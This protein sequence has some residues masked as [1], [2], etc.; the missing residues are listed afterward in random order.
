MSYTELQT[1]D[2]TPESAAMFWRSISEL[3]LTEVSVEVASET[4][5]LEATSLRWRATG[6]GPI[7]VRLCIFNL[8]QS[9]EQLASS[10]TSDA[11]YD[12]AIDNETQT[13]LSFLESVRPFS[14]RAEYT[15]NGSASNFSA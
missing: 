3:G 10:A 8:M 11:E 15:V 5:T 12:V 13:V 4:A 14:I 9:W 6:L 1:D 2:L 7:G